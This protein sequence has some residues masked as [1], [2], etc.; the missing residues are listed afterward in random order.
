MSN[1]YYS[2]E[3]N[4]ELLKKNIDREKNYSHYKQI[5]LEITKQNRV[6]VSCPVCEKKNIQRNIFIS[7][8]GIDYIQCFECSH[9]Y[10]DYLPSEKNQYLNSV[11]VSERMSKQLYEDKTKSGRPHPEKEDG[12]GGREE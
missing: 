11:K 8:Y 4:M 3:I 6:L 9:I 1:I 12:R 10:Q 5:C 2:K 7:I